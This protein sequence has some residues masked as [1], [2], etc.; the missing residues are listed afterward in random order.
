MADLININHAPGRTSDMHPWQDEAACL[1]AEDPDIFFPESGEVR[2]S[3][4][5]AEWC[6]ICPVAKQ[7]FDYAVAAGITEGIFGGTTPRARRPHIT[8]KADQR[9]ANRKLVATMTAQHMTAAEIAESLGI[10]MR[11]V[12][13]LRSKKA[14]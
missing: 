12:T 6:S 8:G 10:T 4:E 9:Q 3:L 2:K 13:R 14:S 7:C 5:A 11:Q 1:D